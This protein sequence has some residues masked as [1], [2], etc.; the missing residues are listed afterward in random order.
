[1]RKTIRL[2]A[3]AAGGL[4][5]LSVSCEK[6]E[7]PPPIDTEKEF[8]KATIYQETYCYDGNNYYHA[9]LDSTV[10]YKSDSLTSYLK[11]YNYKTIIK[12]PDLLKDISF[13]G[14]SG[15]PIFYNKTVK[16]IFIEN[17]KYITPSTF[18]IHKY[19]S[20]P[21]DGTPQIE[22]TKIE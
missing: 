12:N 13:R 17:Y 8:V 1:M 21:R 16:F 11:K 2:L 22:L 19:L 20:S 14:V 6:V 10:K 3:L 7:E 5:M 4:L 18:C 9:V 15:M